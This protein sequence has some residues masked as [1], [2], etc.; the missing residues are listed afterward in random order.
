MH[1]TT[2][3]AFSDTDLKKYRHTFLMR[4]PQKTIPSYYRATIGDCG[5]FG[6]FDPNEAGFAELETLVVSSIPSE[7]TTVVLLREK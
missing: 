7:R 6:E 1:I 3:L 5:D 2:V 4:D